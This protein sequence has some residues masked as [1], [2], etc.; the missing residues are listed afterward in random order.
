MCHKLY[1]K[2][3]SSYVCYYEEG[4]KV[5]ALDNGKW[6]IVFDF[7]LEMGDP[8][9]NHPQMTVHSVDTINVGDNYYKRLWFGYSDDEGNLYWIEGVGST[10]YGPFNQITEDI[11]PMSLRWEGLMS[12]YDGQTCIF[13]KNDFHQPGIDTGIR[14]NNDYQGS[15]VIIQEYKTVLFNLQGRRLTTE[16][17]HGVYIRNG[18]KVVR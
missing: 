8:C 1:S 13:E 5:Y 10:R 17:K 9:P 11:S 3:S 6:I 14:Y 7:T 2:S 15:L 18:K 4:G 12:V 16:P